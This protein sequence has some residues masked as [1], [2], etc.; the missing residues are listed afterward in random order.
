M[1]PDW[2]GWR[3]IPDIFCVLFFVG[4]GGVG[5]G[6]YAVLWDL[7]VAVCTVPAYDT[8]APSVGG[9]IPVHNIDLCRVYDCVWYYRTGG[10]SGQLAIQYYDSGHLDAGGV[11]VGD[12]GAV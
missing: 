12:I 10:Q 5:G 9:I 3:G 2:C 6:I 11:R 4:A 8:N 1:L 7:H